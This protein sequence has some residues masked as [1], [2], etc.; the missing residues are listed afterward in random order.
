V[1]GGRQPVGEGGGVLGRPA[2]VRMGGPTIAIFTALG[3]PAPHAFSCLG[4]PARGAGRKVERDRCTTPGYGGPQISNYD[5]GRPE[6]DGEARL[7]ARTSTTLPASFGARRSL[8]ATS[9][10][11]TAAAFGAALPLTADMAR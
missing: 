8:A 10:T 3:L 1:A 7:R 11:E 9:G 4:H 6:R 2:L 5:P